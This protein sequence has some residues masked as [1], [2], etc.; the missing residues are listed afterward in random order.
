MYIK[1]SPR[2][3]AEINKVGISTLAGVYV[4]RMV[5]HNPDTEYNMKVSL[6]N[7]LEILQDY[8]NS[9]MDK[10]IVNI[11]VTSAEL[12][13]IQ[14]NIQGLECVITL[15]AFDMEQSVE[16]VKLPP[17]IIKTKA[18][19]DPVDISKLSNPA[20]VN[21]NEEKS[22][23]NAQ[24]AQLT[25]KYSLSL[26]APAIYD[27][28]HTS[29]NTILNK[30]NM[31]QVVS[32][33]CYQFGFENVYIVPPDNTQVYNTV[34]IPPVKDISNV[35]T[36]LQNTYGIYSKGLGYYVT[37]DNT[38]YIYPQF[39]LDMDHATIKNAVHIIHGPTEYYTGMSIYHNVIDN[40]LW[41]LS[42]SS[43][44]MKSPTSAAEENNGNVML[45]TNADNVLDN[46]VNIDAKGNVTRDE[47][48][49][50]VIQSAND[51]AMSKSANVMKYKGLC[52][53]IYK[54]T[55]EIAS[56]TGTYLSVGWTTAEPFIIR[57]GM[58][59]IYQYDDANNNF[60]IKNGRPMAVSYSSVVHKTNHSVHFVMTFNC[61]I[62]LFIEPEKE[63]SDIVN[64]N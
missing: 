42:I 38:F 11:D 2:L 53:N 27:I 48:N 46:R 28:R 35:F 23:D 30:V 22:P 3:N 17:I 60:K 45:Y 29:I 5:L 41:I 52:S 25:V 12:I 21:L 37:T 13:A 62:K 64:L 59:F 36:Y 55:S 1:T 15:T 20:Q 57:P 33:L 19:V 51:N 44:D 43:V 7:S 8:Y 9:Y 50:T 16:L 49:L 47:K 32:W 10:I 6:I 26:V 14:N 18:I 4:A 54:A 24:Q 58:H 56:Y 63:T 39:A 34:I 61:N 31:E 40:D